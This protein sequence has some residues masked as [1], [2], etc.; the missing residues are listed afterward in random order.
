MAK[1]DNQR[2]LDF[3]KVA[4]ER[5]FTRNFQ[6]RVL[7]MSDKGGSIITQDDL[8]Y[9][10]S[11]QIPGRTIT[12]IPTPYMGLDFNVPGAAKYPG[13]DAYAITFY[14]DGEHQI[15]SVFE[16][17]TQRMFDDA[18]STGEY[19]LHSNSIITLAQLDQQMEVTRTYQL[20]GCYPT[21]CGELEFNMTGN[22]EVVQFT[23]TMA[24]Q[25]WR[26]R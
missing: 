26:R 23:A 7:D 2:I 8:V 21:A 10:Q 1:F 24:Y 6:F 11:A 4:Q 19:R 14:A 12:N 16:T 5:D 15:R 18:T 9:A 20:V 3:Y 17:W 13:S 22:G 25:F